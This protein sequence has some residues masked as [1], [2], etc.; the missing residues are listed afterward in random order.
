MAIQERLY[1]EES[2]H[3]FSFYKRLALLCSQLGDRISAAK[4]LKQS[5]D[6]LDKWVAEA[7]LDGASDEMKKEMKQEQVRIY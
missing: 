5:L 6:L 1:G 4:Y 3:M 2:K 7:A